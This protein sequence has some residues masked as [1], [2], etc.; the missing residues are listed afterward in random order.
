RL[1]Y[2]TT[3]RAL[4]SRLL[5]LNLRD[6]MNR[7]LGKDGDRY[8]I[9]GRAYEYLLQKFGQNK[10]FAEYFTPRHVVDRM[11]QIIDPQIDETVYDPACGTGG[12]CPTGVC[13]LD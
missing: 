8:D 9:F 13:G 4:T 11:V 2:S 7:A 6:I 10:E 12:C 1:R 3:V 5:E